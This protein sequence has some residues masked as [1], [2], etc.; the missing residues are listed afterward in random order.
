VINFRP[1]HNERTNCRLCLDGHFVGPPF[2]RVVRASLRRFVGFSC[3][4]IPSGV[5]FGGWDPSLYHVYVF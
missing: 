3:L 4:S 1:F 5:S 2:L